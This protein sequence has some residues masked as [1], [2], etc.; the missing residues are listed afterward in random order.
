MTICGSVI[1]GDY[2]VACSN[3][4]DAKQNLNQIM[5]EERVKGFVDIVVAKNILEGISNL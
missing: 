5:E 3:A 2:T 4:I 1:T